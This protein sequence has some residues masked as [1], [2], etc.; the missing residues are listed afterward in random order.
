MGISEAM[1]LAAVALIGYL[2]G[3]RTR[4]AMLKRSCADMER[5]VE[6]AAQVAGRLERIAVT[7]RQALANHHA[8]VLQFKRR[9]R[10]V[11]DL[12]GE[13][14]WDA[15]CTEAETVLVPTMAL[16]SQLSQAY[17][18]LRQQSLALA[19][20]TAGRVDPLTCIATAQ[21]F[22]EQVAFYLRCQLSNRKSFSVALLTADLQHSEGQSRLD[23]DRALQNV[24]H[25][26]QRSVR[27]HD[28]LARYGAE[29]FAILLPDTKLQGANLFG[30]RIRTLVKDQLGIT[31]SIGLAESS[32][33]DDAK[34]LMVRSDSALYSARTKGGDQQFSHTGT[35]IRSQTDLMAGTSSEPEPLLERHDSRKSTSEQMDV[36]LDELSEV[37]IEAGA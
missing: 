30:A 17:D 13:E 9:L 37:L 6:R 26:L 33:E 18:E 22:D 20:F 27:G 28:F 3:R 1:G 24:A 7:L 23:G 5:E 12:P 15:M 25:L 21:A 19:A 11:R 29:E 8:Q 16:A 2:F 10:Q 36:S 31:L 4:T 14:S 32:L 35:A 34:S